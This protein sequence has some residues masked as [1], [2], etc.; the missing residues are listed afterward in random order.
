MSGNELDRTCLDYSFFCFEPS[1]NLVEVCLHGD[2]F[3]V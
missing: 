3:R 1:K 2:I